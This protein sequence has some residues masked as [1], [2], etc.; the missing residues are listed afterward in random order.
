MP[1]LGILHIIAGLP[2]ISAARDEGSTPHRCGGTVFEVTMR[3]RR[4]HA[5][6]RRP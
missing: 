1:A 4:V 5:R 2:A 3:R 6:P